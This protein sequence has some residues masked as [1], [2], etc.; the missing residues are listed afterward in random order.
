M[1]AAHLGSL[2]SRD[3]WQS[4]SFWLELWGISRIWCWGDVTSTLLDVAAGRVPM[5]VLDAA[6]PSCDEPIIS[7]KDS[8]TS[9]TMRLLLWSGAGCNFASIKSLVFLLFKGTVLPPVPCCEIS[10]RDT[11]SLSLSLEAPVKP[12]LVLP[13][14]CVSVGLERAKHTGLLG[15]TDD[16]MLGTLKK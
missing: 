3:L 11:E 1:A 12:G 8:F 15:E 2:G 16:N 5:L 10:A 7:G 4:P 6:F 13:G 9:P 14:I